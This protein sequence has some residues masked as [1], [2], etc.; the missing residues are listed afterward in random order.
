MPRGSQHP[1]GV[2]YG[3]VGNG[4]GRCA[5][6][7]E[8]YLEMYHLASDCSRDDTGHRGMG[9]AERL[10]RSSATEFAGPAITLSRTAATPA[11]R[12]RRGAVTGAA[13]RGQRRADGQGEHNDAG[14]SARGGS[15]LSGPGTHVCR[16]VRNGI[17]H[18]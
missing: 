7:L 5:E 2:A 10:R 17:R 9:A 3:P 18:R 11:G 4:D 6:A 14:V 12:R 13:H 15:P 8:R 1:C 16:K